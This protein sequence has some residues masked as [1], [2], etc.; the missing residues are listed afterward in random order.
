M[1]NNKVKCNSPIFSTRPT[2]Y[3]TK[4]R[5]IS[6]IMSVFKTSYAE[7]GGHQESDGVQN[8][9]LHHVFHCYYIG[10]VWFEFVLNL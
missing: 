1:S 7:I 6:I 9:I 3:P 8:D 2:Q 10:V 4:Y 5:T